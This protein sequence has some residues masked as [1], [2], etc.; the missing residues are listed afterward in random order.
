MVDAEPLVK[1]G[2]RLDAQ[3]DTLGEWLADGAAYDAAGADALWID[4]ASGAQLDAVALAAALAVMSARSQ[5]V[6]VFGQA[7]RPSPELARSID[8][9]RRLSHQRLALAAEPERAEALADLVPD[10]P[11]LRREPDGSG[12]VDP[13]AA[14]GELSRW[15]ATPAPEGRSAWRETRARAAARGAH[16]V[17]VPSGP[18][19]LDVLR[20]PGEPGGRRDL[21]LA[22]G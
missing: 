20:N 1:V 11:I 4:L 18:L 9:V 16:G 5:V 3:P 8:T 17:V 6:V 7:E 19:L 13:R 10:L 22:Q 12:W 14:D 21:R 2:V 15:I